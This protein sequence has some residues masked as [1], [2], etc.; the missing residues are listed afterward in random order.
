MPCFGTCIESYDTMI[1]YEMVLGEIKMSDAGK[2][3]VNRLKESCFQWFKDH[4]HLP[5]S[6]IPMHLHKTVIQDME[7]EFDVGW[8]VKKGEK[9]NVS[10]LQEI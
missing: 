1:E 4:L 5:S 6:K 7:F 9:A 8:S 2:V 3:F 10:K